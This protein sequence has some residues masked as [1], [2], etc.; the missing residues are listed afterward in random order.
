MLH[1][2]VPISPYFI[3]NYDAIMNDER[4]QLMSFEDQQLIYRFK[5]SRGNFEKQ[6]RTY[7]VRKV[8]KALHKCGYF[9]PLHHGDYLTYA[10]T[11][12]QETLEP[13]QNLKYD[14]LLCTRV[15]MNMKPFVHRYRYIFYADTET[16]T[17]Q[18]HQEYN[19][20][21]IR[22]D[23][24][25]RCQIFGLNCVT[26]FL[27]RMPHESLIYF[28]N[29]SYDINFIVNKLTRC[30][31]P[32]I[33]N[34]RTFE[35]SGLYK[36][37]KLTFKDSFAIINRPL[38]DFPAMFKLDSGEKE[39]FPETYYNSELV[40]KGNTV[41]IISEALKHV[42]EQ[43]REHFVQNIDNIKNCQ[44][45]DEKFKLDVYSNFYCDQDVKILQLG[46]ENF[47]ASLLKEFELD[48]YD[49]ISISSIANKF[50][51]REV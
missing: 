21:F 46:F 14:P 32:I 28:H 13:L 37:K 11:L 47:R 19:I 22:N 29:L 9:V 34:G 42:K 1:E 45:S 48:V 15:K 51:E 18:I 30:F 36:G 27:E 3:K 24:K 2:E 43:A 12:Y 44:I 20:C 4:A 17:D 23:G 7:D 40:A 33:K 35:L 31:P 49:F 5:E 41:E 39:V 8:I 26:E 50:L 16:C 10:S 25:C 6:N 38:R